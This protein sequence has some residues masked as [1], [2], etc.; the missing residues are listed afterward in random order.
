MSIG[1]DTFGIGKGDF[2]S[3]FSRIVNAHR[4]GSKLIGEPRNFI[5]TACRL[6]SRFSKVA[7]EPDV[8]VRV[9]NWQCGPRKVKMAILKRPDGFKQPVPKNQLVD[10]LYPPRETVR[11]PNLERKHVSSVRAAMRQLVD[12]Q[13]RRYR[14]SLEYPIECHVTGKSLRPGM[15]VDIDHLG[16]PFV[17]L[18][19]EW[20]S[21]LGITYCDL[22]LCG[23]PN[24]KRFKE[25]K[26]NDAWQIFHEDNARL[27]AVCAAANRS[28]GA[29]G[30][31]TPSDVLGSFAKTSD[32][33]IDLAF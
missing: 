11:K 13:L 4:A 24:L 33:E 23:P 15:R 18:A 17:Q 12:A 2:S 5:I 21:S 22:T 10:Q 32:E 30:Y 3:K 9:E 16:K 19:D 26:Y 25:A 31:E 1:K 20:V 29:S 8:E 27:I 28:K 14:S 7:N 6:A